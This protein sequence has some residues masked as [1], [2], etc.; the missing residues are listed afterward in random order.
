MQAD[1]FTRADP[2]QNLLKHDG[3]LYVLGQLMDAAQAQLVFDELH[4]SLPWQNE[5]LPN[6]FSQAP[7]F[8][9]LDRKLSLHT[10]ALTHYRYSGADKPCQPWTPL[11]LKLKAQ[12][13]QRTG[14]PF[15]VCLANLYPD[16]KAS[17]GWHS[18]NETQLV[19]GSA[20]ASL[21]LGA[22]RDFDVKH[23]RSG[24]K[25]RLNLKSGQLVVMGG[26][27]Q[28]HWLHAIPKRMGLKEPRINLTFRLM[29]PDRK[30]D[31]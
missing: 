14:Q 8:F 25:L 22:A 21:S 11:L 17:M 7:E 2:E 9:V 10:E 23:K 6:R 13:E 16:G 31:Q 29:H 12:I 30:C 19:Q 15:N 5:V 26:A 1:L 20:I 3:E 27:V 4:A 28:Q 18:D 24:E